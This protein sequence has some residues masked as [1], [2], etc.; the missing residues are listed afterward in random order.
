M[1]YPLASPTPSPRPPA[2]WTQPGVTSSIHPLRPPIIELRDVTRV[3]DT[4]RVQVAALAG[5]DFRVAEGEFVAIVGPSGSGKSTLMNVLGCLDRPTSGTYH[6]AG[7]DVGSLSDDGLAQLRS[8]R[9]GFV[10]QSYNLLPRTSALDNVAA[11]LMY[12]GVSAGR[13]RTLAAAALERLGLGDRLDHEP[14]E[15]SGGQQQRVAVA[16]AIVT[17]PALILA[18]EPTGNLDT[19]SGSE[20]MALLH[21]LH[22]SGRTIV[23][24]THEAEVASQANRQIHIRDGRVAP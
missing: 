21:E 13:R 2:V 12:Q 24:I 23:L 5:V 10:F 9:I 22:R 14:T 17:D 1:T 20:V 7:V 18:D 4:G 15:L 11:P 19:H 6:L 16:R 8:R 3:Y